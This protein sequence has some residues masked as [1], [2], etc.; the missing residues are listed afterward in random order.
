MLM[1]IHIVGKVGSIL[2]YVN[3]RCLALAGFS[4]QDMYVL[5]GT[6]VGTLVAEN[7]LTSSAGKS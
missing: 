1:V 3:S 7:T 4:Y 6:M 5:F 2:W